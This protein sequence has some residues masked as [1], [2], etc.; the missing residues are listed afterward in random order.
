MSVSVLN[1]SLDAQ[2]AWDPSRVALGDPAERQRR[3]ARHLGALHVVVKTAG[4]ITADRVTLAPNAWAY[5][6]RS[7]SRYTFVADALRI[8]ARLLTRERIDVV[9]AQDPFATGLVCALLAWRFG[10]PLNVQVHFDV[11]DNPHWLAEKREHR[12][13]NVLGKALVRRADT[14]RVGTTR[15][16]ERFGAWG[17][18]AERI[19]VAPVPVD[20][21]AFASAAD[22]SG[23]RRLIVNASRLVPQKD[24]P[25]LLRACRQVFDALPGAELAV[26]GDGPLR[27]G[28]EQ[29][30]RELGIAARVR[31]LGRVD[32]HA[33]PALLGSASALV[34]SS[35]YEGTSLVTV[36][37][38]AAGKPVV[39]TDVAGAS[40]TVIDGE[41]GRVVTVGDARALADA[42]IEI[43]RDPARAAAMGERGRAHVLQRFDHERA[44]TRV[45]EMWDQTRR[46]PKAGW[47]YLANVRVPSEK[48]HV[49]QIF[50]MLDAFR[51]AGVRVTL[52]HPRRENIAE[53]ADTDPVVLYGLRHRPERHEA[54][55]LDAIKRV[56]I[57]RPA[58]NRAPL[59]QLAFAL[60]SA[61]FA[62]SAARAVSRLR[63]RV[64]YSRDWAI[65]C[66]ALP[67]GVPCVWEA[68]DLP[69][70][71]F[72][73]R[74]LRALL[75]RLR[76]IVAIT[77][78]LRNELLEQGV[79]PERLLV[80]PDAVNLERFEGRPNRAAARAQL[81]L[82]PECRYAVYTGHL[83]PW[84]GAHTLARAAAGLPADV[85]VLIVGGTPAD[86]EAFRR[87][88]SD[89]RAERVRVVG[90]VP[91]AEVPIWLAAADVLVLPNSGGEAIS[92][93]YTSP[94][95]LFE[96]MAAHRPIVAS[97]LPSV[98]EVLRH[99]ENGW[100]VR[101]DSPAALAAGITAL[102]DDASLAERLATRARQDVSGRTWTARATQ[103]ARFVDEVAAC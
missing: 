94:L 89:E 81:G 37:A 62:A 69:Q 27:P 50:Q 17:I 85:E 72:T 63:P 74:A 32:R 87:F 35:R 11:L 2:I 48:A 16:A 31:F 9:S 19:F 46:T 92:M 1:V 34:V 57:D 51:D 6:T 54:G 60:Q 28:L 3:Y 76:G 41:T 90:H 40:D 49:Y 53:L 21:A 24:L 93:R 67:L 71:R 88:V 43:L 42:L 65:L 13:L 73:R 66:A 8:G 12:V 83:Y 68:H 7:R 96:Y 84:K 14:V 82:K 20:L 5:P 45:V 91:P 99:G 29:L 79:P 98:R 102:L 22:T 75:S 100:L 56:T 70:G 36:Q 39:T 77:E 26:A 97:D 59:P 23:G 58:L 86:L 15:E 10:K 80:A 55:A 33:M 101:P 47:V 95:K 44:V 30:A 78:G 103:I 25:T 18:A 38:A 4:D 64:V 61:T 52:V